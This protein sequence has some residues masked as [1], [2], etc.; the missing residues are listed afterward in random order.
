[1]PSYDSIDILW[2]TAN[3][4]LI[5]LMQ[6]GFAMVETGTVRAKNTINVA[7]K[8]LIDTI[9]GVIV[10][11]LVG[12]A[13][14]FGA[15]AGG[16]V[17]TDRFLI[18]G[19]DHTES[20]FFFFQSMYAATAMTIVSGAVAERMK[21]N[22]YVFASIIVIAFIYPIFGH[23]AWHASGWLASAGF[24][25][26]AGSTVVHSVGAWIGLA[27][28]LLLGPRLGKFRRGRIHYFAPSNH[29]FIVF[30]IFVLWFAWFG[31]NAGSLLAFDER[32][33]KILLNTTIAAA[34]GGMAAYLITL[35][36]TRRVGAE[37]FSFGILAGLVSITAGCDTLSAP[38]AAG[39][40]FAATFIMF[41]AD[42][43]LLRV[44]RID[45]PLS[46][47]GIHGFAG[48]W[49]T[50]AVGIFAA[51]PAG[52]SRFDFI[53]VQLLG[54]AA[55][56]V[57]A[58]GSGLLLFALLIPFGA[59]RVSRRNEVKGL[60]LS[61]H[62]A[63]LPWVETVESI[64]RIMRTGNVTARIYEEKNT[65]VGVIV[66]FFNYL[67]A[68]IRQEQIALRR[69]NLELHQKAHTDPLTAILNRRGLM[70]YIGEK[71]PYHH[72]FSIILVDVDRFKSIN[73][74]YGH[75]V[76]DQV[77]RE[78]SQVIRKKL[79]PDDL[80]GRWGGEEFLLVIHSLDIAAVEARAEAL[81]TAIAAH[82]F[83]KVGKVT[84]SFGVSTP[85]REAITLSELIRQADQAM[86]QAKSLGRD[87]VCS[88]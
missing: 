5:F 8:N 37:I 25:D 39:V 27:G 78:T 1:M 76:G 9:F 70:D 10:F 84:A 32:V 47:V 43:F 83:T 48:A 26:F 88:W 86:Y 21:F 16:F 36:Y 65:E 62:D 72:G 85:R 56:F 77:L 66:R 73:D 42:Q 53:T 71:P 38:Q 13:L 23:W 33:A 49:G 2:I 41:A 15:D 4:F 75:A 30:G 81:R 57:F 50:L 58:F 74:R 87:R 28:A 64:I 34:F 18:D 6:L 68:I 67:L 44:L 52:M 55:A 80:F 63:K 54:I 17:G 61:E 69:T 14:M 60:N 40:G 31:F 82:H 3:A 35:G 29:N 22:G 46:V 59:L 11:W 19:R 24:V 12:F 45:D 20:S 7:M 79:Q 51:L